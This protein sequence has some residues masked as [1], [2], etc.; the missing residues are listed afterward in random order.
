[1]FSSDSTTG[2]EDSRGSAHCV[3]NNKGKIDACME[4]SDIENLQ[5]MKS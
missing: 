4:N 2:D 5:A 1:M 3:S